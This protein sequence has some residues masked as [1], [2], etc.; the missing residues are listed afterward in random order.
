VNAE[1]TML[2]DETSQKVDH[3]ASALAE[4]FGAEIR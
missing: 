3:I 4:Q 2:D 1:Q